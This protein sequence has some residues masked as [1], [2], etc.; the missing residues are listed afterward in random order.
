[1]DG[2]RDYSVAPS[3]PGHSL[4][5]PETCAGLRLD[6]ALAQCF[7]QYSRSQIKNWVEAGRVRVDGSEAA[8]KRRMRGLE[9]VTLDPDDSSTQTADRPE[10]IPLGIVFEDDH[11]VVLDKPAGLVV[12][13]GAGNRTG[14]LLNALLSHAPRLEHLP[15][16]GIVHRLDKETS[17][18]MVVAKTLEAQTDL[19]RQLQARSV[20]RVYLAI[21]EGRIEKSGSVDAPIGRHPT[22]RTRMAIVERGRPARTHYRPLQSGSGWTL[23]ECTL[24]TGRTHQIRVH[25][26]HIGHPLVGDPVYGKRTSIILRSATAF[27][28]QALHATTLSLEHPASGARMSWSSSPPAD[29]DDLLNALKTAC[30]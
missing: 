27:N 3:G 7:P 14:T 19:V 21:A 25:L 12:H 18:L 9:T 10:D 17:G 29:F 13:P 24:E 1:M 8:P 26:Q 4:V 6:Q 22:H 11:I 23:V 28:R 5:V 20:S 2:E 30:P 16:A 15:R